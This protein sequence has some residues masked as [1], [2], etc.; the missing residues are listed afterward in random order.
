MQVALSE[1][2]KDVQELLKAIV[3]PGAWRREVGQE[4]WEDLVKERDELGD[5]KI[6]LVL[7]LYFGDDKVEIVK[8][9]IRD[10]VNQRID[11]HLYI[12]FDEQP[13]SVQ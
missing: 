1:P 8:K 6:A 9:D 7:V 11:I 4:G 2:I 10:P 13:Q 12:R 3:D 5:I